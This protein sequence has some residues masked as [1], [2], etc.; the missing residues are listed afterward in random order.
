MNKIS[1]ICVV[2]QAWVGSIA[3]QVMS[4]AEGVLERALALWSGWFSKT[5]IS[6]DLRQGNLKTWDDRLPFKNVL[7]SSFLDRANLRAAIAGIGSGWYCGKTPSFRGLLGA[8]FEARCRFALLGSESL[9]KGA[10]Q[11]LFVEMSIVTVSRRTGRQC[12]SNRRPLSS[13]GIPAEAAGAVH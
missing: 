13:W 1:D 6:L 10:K 12:V 2:P 4:W 5:K 9:Q 7:R 8:P 11:H 3:R